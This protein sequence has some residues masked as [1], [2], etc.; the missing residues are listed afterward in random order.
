MAG[1]T[2]S[3]TDKPVL[4]GFY[5]A[6]RSAATAAIQPGSRGVAI[7]PVRAHWGPIN[8]FVDISSEVEIANAFTRSEENGAT[9]YSALKL[10]LLGG[11]RKVFA[12]RLADG[13]AAVA[14]VTL[15]DSASTPVN[16]VK[17]EAKYPGSRGNDFKVTVQVN[18]TDSGKKDLKLFEGTTL[19][20]TFTF[21]GN[22]V[23]AAVN[24]INGD[25]GNK[26]ITATNLGEGNG[27]LA[28]VS[29]IS[30]TGGNSGIAAIANAEYLNALADFET[31]DFNVVFLDGVSDSGLHAS[32]AAW[33]GRIRDEGKGVIAVF[34]GSAADDKAAD[35]VSKAISRSAAMNHE[36]IVNV[37]TG[38]KFNGTSY[39]SAQVTAYVAGLIAGQGLSQSTTYAPSPFEDVTRRW[40]RSE[41]EQAVRN[42][43]FLLVHDGRLVKALRGINSLVTLREGQNNPWK[44]IR[45]IRVMDSINSDLQRT[46]E[47]AYI[48]KVN[49]TEEGRLA[50]I[51][52]CKQYMQSLAQAGIIEAEGYD[53]YVD[54]EFTPE[55]DQVFLKWEARL[56]DVMEQIFSTFIVR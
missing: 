44:K 2:W 25:A 53:V 23:K 38:V 33:V 30:L 55:P 42:G 1:G 18:P 39:S 45:T 47:D 46:A 14:T 4:P 43:V 32:V 54:T 5:M 50:L 20:R 37:G 34:G 36:G 31:Q 49:N 9:A 7:A 40:T 56:T 3:T 22:S 21:A 13:N 17:L 15:A 48:G 41:Q 19:L 51:G 12:Y 10:A 29:G 6:F 16:V 28:N 24:E 26:W 52:A 27:T 11:A 35:A 8:Q